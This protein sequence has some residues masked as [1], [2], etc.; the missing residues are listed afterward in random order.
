MFSFAHLIYEAMGV[1]S[2]VFLT[3]H[4]TMFNSPTS[5]T[6]EFHFRGGSQ[7]QRPLEFTS[8]SSI[9]LNDVWNLLRSNTDKAQSRLEIRMKFCSSEFRRK[10]RATL[11]VCVCVF[12]KR[13]RVIQ[14]DF[15]LP[16]EKTLYLG[17]NLLIH[18]S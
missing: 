18:C 13:T 9:T 4:H 6:Q 1:T 7:F 5:R 11:C 3:W 12:I 16:L 2:P 8:T 17:T 14:H 15:M 10:N